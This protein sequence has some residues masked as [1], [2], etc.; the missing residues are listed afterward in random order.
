MQ[1]LDI[2]GKVYESRGGYMWQIHI[3]QQGDTYKHSLV[4]PTLEKAQEDM[5]K[6]MRELVCSIT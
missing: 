2:Y 6:H 5:E 1:G 3:Q 4:Y